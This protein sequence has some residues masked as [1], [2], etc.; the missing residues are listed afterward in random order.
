M[1]F[2][3]VT[4]NCNCI[5]FV[6][7]TKSKTFVWSNTLVVLKFQASLFPRIIIFLSW[8]KSTLLLKNKCFGTTIYMKTQCLQTNE[9]QHCLGKES[10][11]V[12]S[13]LR[14]CST[15][16]KNIGFTCIWFFYNRGRFHQCSTYNFYARRAQKRKMTM[17][18]WVSFF[19]HAGSMC[20]KVV[21]RMLMKSSP[22]VRTW[23][24]PYKMWFKV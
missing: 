1:L 8:L 5:K 9:M 6:K 13:L 21:R 24:K 2:I 12:W 16:S 11:F 17:L 4:I 18:T 22:D 7:I 10:Y 14:E 19:V 23:R 3:V 20:I 15:F